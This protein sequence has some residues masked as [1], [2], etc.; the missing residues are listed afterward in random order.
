MPSYR[1]QSIDLPCTQVDWFIYDGDFVVS[2]VNTLIIKNYILSNARESTLLKRL[3]LILYEYVR[4]WNQIFKRLSQDFY[5]NSLVF[6]YWFFGYWVFRFSGCNFEKNI[7]I[8]SSTFPQ[9]RVNLIYPK[10]WNKSAL[11][12]NGQ[13][14]N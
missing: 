8:I 11:P 6:P 12:I 2:L 13:G 14:G 10:F 9:M 4:K 3:S 7:L 1:I 5:K